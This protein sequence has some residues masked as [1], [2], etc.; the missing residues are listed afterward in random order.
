MN[1]LEES[2]RENHSP[3]WAQWLSDVFSPITVPT[4]GMVVAL[5]CTNMRSLPAGNRVLA[6][7]LIA[8][9]TAALPF[10]TI[11]WLIKTGR[12]HTRSIADR[13]ER[14]VPMAVGGGC[15]LGA[16]IVIAAMSAPSWLIFFF[17]G[18]ALATAIAMLVTT[19]W[20]ISAHTTA[21]GGFVGMTAWCAVGGV[22][23]LAA[24]LALSTSLL[25]AGSVATARLALGRHTLGQVA[26]GL[27][28]GFVCC[29]FLMFI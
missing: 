18:A 19:R 17:V 12:V 28:L 2:Y 8:L 7:A 6:T 16:A 27:A 5:W 24:M 14:M 4:F 13:R 9:I 10:A 15:Y 26:A 3:A 29:F 1:E 11:A 23:D 22:A 25:I 21:I 20:K